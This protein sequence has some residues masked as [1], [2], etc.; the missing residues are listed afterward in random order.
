[1]SSVLGMSSLLDMARRPRFP[2]GWTPLPLSSSWCERLLWPP[3]P[4]GHIE[5][6]YLKIN[7]GLVRH[8]FYIRYD[9]DRSTKTKCSLYSVHTILCIFIK[10]KQIANLFP[11]FSLSVPVSL[12]YFTY[13]MH[14]RVSPF[15]VSF[16]P[17]RY[18]QF[19]RPVRCKGQRS[20]SVLV[21]VTRICGGIFIYFYY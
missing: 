19:S 8:G 17:T 11:A 14:T 5:T 7:R 6:K 3:R 15:C 10:G 9:E 20:K 1:M 2:P 12:L 4:P 21:L 13:T 16:N 18:A